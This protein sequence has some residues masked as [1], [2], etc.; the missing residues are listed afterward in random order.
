MSWRIR[1]YLTGA[2][3]NPAS[4][5]PNL[6]PI[7]AGDISTK[8][9]R[10]FNAEVGNVISLFTRLKHGDMV[11]SPSLGHYNP[12]LIGEVVGDWT[13]GDLIAIEYQRA[14]ITEDVPFRR[15]RWIR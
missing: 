4:R 15:V 3:D 6:Y 11:L 10:R 7:E 12:M 8:R 9:G 1:D 13:P 14:G 2:K 5:T